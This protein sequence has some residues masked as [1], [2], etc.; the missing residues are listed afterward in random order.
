MSRSGRSRFRA[1]FQTTRVGRRTEVH[2]NSEP[3]S[4]STNIPVSL[5][6]EHSKR[7]PSTDQGKQKFYSDPPS[8]AKIKC[9]LMSSC[10]TV[11]LADCTARTKSLYVLH[12]Y[13]PTSDCV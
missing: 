10:V 8:W 4:L 1:A 7:Q 6:S 12:G 3:G 5:R 13:T 11:G 2:G 9:C